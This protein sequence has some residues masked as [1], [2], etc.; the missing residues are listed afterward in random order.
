MSDFDNSTEYQT[1]LRSV[2]YDSEEIDVLHRNI[3][4][5]SEVSSDIESKMI[6]I[7]STDT[8]YVHL[9]IPNDLSGL[10]Y[11]YMHEYEWYKLPVL[12]RLLK[13]SISRFTKG[14]P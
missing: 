8:M 7:A 14:S 3:K 2:K 12:N 4:N 11:L 13:K 1:I 5:I 9:C 10:L 6:Y